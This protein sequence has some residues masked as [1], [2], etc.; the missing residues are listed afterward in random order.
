MEQC[1]YNG[2]VHN[3]GHT[4]N[5]GRLLRLKVNSLGKQEQLMEITYLSK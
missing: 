2:K 4:A 5:S 3:D 1:K